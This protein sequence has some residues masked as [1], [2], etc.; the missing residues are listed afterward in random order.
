[1]CVKKKFEI[2]LKSVIIS[3]AILFRAEHPLLMMVLL[4]ILYKQVPIV[5]FRSESQSETCKRL[6]RNTAVSPHY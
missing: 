4:Q 2:V 6:G 3:L 1:M 5:I